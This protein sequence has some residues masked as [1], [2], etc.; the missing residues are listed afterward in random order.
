ML[1]S[2]PHYEAC[3]NHERTDG[4]HAS[5]DLTAQTMNRATNSGAEN[6]RK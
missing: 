1:F 6:T 4:A 5:L 2:S 3:N